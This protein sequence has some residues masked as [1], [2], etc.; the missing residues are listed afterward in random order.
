[1][2]A[3]VYFLCK[4]KKVDKHYNSIEYIN[5]D[6]FIYLK[7]NRGTISSVKSE[8]MQHIEMVGTKNNNN[9]SK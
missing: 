8:R 9:L 4:V 5:R 3:S 1:M 2:V 6:N 7:K